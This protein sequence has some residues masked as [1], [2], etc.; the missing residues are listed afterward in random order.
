MQKCNTCGN[1][2]SPSCDWQQGRCP[3]HPPVVSEYQKRF[4]NLMQSIKN[5]FTKDDCDCGHK[6]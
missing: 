6:H 3:H 5:I 2:Y 4:Y 1:E